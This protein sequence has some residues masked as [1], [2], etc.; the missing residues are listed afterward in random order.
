[1][2]PLET[3][4][5]GALTAVDRLGRQRGA[6]GRGAETRDFSELLGAA[7]PSNCFIDRPVALH[8]ENSYECRGVSRGGLR[9]VDP[10][11]FLPEARQDGRVWI[12]E[13]ESPNGRASALTARLLL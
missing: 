3:G 12:V 4:A 6:R 9:L 2:H 8:E 1:M 10:K 11:V 13:F 5:V 7:H